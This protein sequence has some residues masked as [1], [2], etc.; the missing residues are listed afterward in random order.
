LV[1]GSTRFERVTCA[2]QRNR[3]H[4]DLGLSRETVFQCGVTG[5]ARGIAEIV[6]VGMDH[7]LDKV[8]I[9]EERCAAFESFVVERS[10]RTPLLR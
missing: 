5:I 1:C 4:Y 8:G 10:V 7:H 2:I 6:T 9:V 3:W